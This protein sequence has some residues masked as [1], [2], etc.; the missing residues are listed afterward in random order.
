MIGLASMRAWKPIAV[1]TC[2][3]LLAAISGNGL[4]QAG[5]PCAGLVDEVRGAIETDYIGFAMAIRPDQERHAAWQALVSAKHAEALLADDSD[6]TF[7]VHELANFTGDPHVFVLDAAEGDTHAEEIRHVDAGTLAPPSPEDALS[8]L[9]STGK[10]VVQIV[11]D[12]AGEASTWIA[13]VTAPSEVGWEPGD[14]IASFVRRGDALWAHLVRREGGVPV[15]RVALLEREETFLHMAPN[16]WFRRDHAESRDMRAPSITHLGN[17]IEMI[18]LGSMDPKHAPALG[19]LVDAHKDAISSAALLIIDLRA[20]EGGSSQFAAPLMPYIV[21]GDME[22]AMGLPGYPVAI[23]S[24]RM[25]RHY[26]QMRDQHPPGPERDMMD[27][28]LARMAA[29]PGQLVPWF[30][31]RA[32]AA[33]IMQAPTIMPA[34]GGPVAVAILIDRHT[35]SAAEAMVLEA[36][37]SSRVTLFGEATGGS[38]DYQN[39]TMFQVGEGATRHYLGLPTLAW[40]DEVV[41]HGLNASGIRP[42]VDLAPG[43]DWISAVRLHYGLSP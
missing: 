21:S 1:T 15:K 12:P 43:T 33:A 41:A 13:V 11:P 14:V 37:R 40:S 5:E 34:Q 23:A 17:G 29:S 4:A 36:A 2:S 19:E 26:Q 9:W 38:I 18:S 24:D 7:I 16:T 20:N 22:A 6:C 8:G 25:R 39:V 3:I 28:F 30:V 35:L 32:M 42:D 10:T 27:E 31:D